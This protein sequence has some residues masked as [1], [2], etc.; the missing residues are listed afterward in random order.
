V[1][2]F[3]STRSRQLLA[4]ALVL[5]PTT[6]TLAAG[7][8]ADETFTL[9]GPRAG[10]E[11]K[12]TPAGA[13]SERLGIQLARVSEVRLGT[14]DVKALLLEDAQ[15]EA[16]GGL[17]HKMMRTGV[18]RELQADA[19]SGEWLDLADGGGLWALDVV[20]ADAL[21]LRLHFVDVA[22]PVGAELAIYVPRADGVGAEGQ[23][24]SYKAGGVRPDFLSPTLFSER[25]RVE[26]RR[27]A[28]DNSTALPFR[29]VD[30]RHAYRDPLS[31]LPKTGLEKA[32]GPCHNDISCFPDF[33]FTGNA[34]G[35]VNIAGVGACTGTLL[36]SLNG[37]FTPYF[38]TANHCLDNGFDASNSDFYWFYQTNFCG[39]APPSLASRPV[40]SGATLV[41]TGSASDY[42]LLL[43]EGALPTG[44]TWA[45]WTSSAASTG[46]P[47]VAIHHPS[48]DFKRISFGDKDSGSV[49]T[50]FGSASNFITVNWTDGPTEPGSSGSGLFRENTQQ[51]FGT[52]TGGPSA[53]GNESFDCYGAFTAHYTKIKNSLKG[54]SDDSSEQNDSCSK[55]KTARAGRLS[56]R[57]V[58][59]NDE[60]WYK[61]P[62][63]KG[64]TLRFSVEF[65]HANGDIDVE[66]FAGCG[67]D[68]LFNSASANDFEELAVTNTGT[69]TAN[70][71]IRVF[72]YRGENFS[73]TRN[74][75]TQFISVGN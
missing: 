18:V 62:V 43:V 6:A 61:V 32:A 12:A 35:L 29:M 51:L 23:V 27:P 74:S 65:L 67:S 36:N 60:D 72:L 15:A 4:A 70:A 59:Y 49:C 54:G 28:G 56:N 38:L 1:Q 52:L 26:Y 13:P 21:A 14:L 58:K 37:D 31:P 24:L 7:A 66:F 20:S 40:S 10:V 75:Y 46:T 30:V 5:L 55:A 44:L 64:K 45:G 2:L 69:R 47:G 41:S 57:I 17:R 3:S 50:P 9:Q 25:V 48:A 8:T 53:C 11:K 16:A 22:L 33:G 42:T 63:P 73:D 39:A 68:F 19:T 34:V 71:Y